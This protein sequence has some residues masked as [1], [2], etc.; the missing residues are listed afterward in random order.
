MSREKREYGF[1]NTGGRK[2]RALLL[3]LIVLAV[4]I[5][6]CGRTGSGSISADN[7]N[8]ALVQEDVVIQ[9]GDK[10]VTVEEV[11]FYVARRSRIILT[12][13]SALSSL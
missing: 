7:G 11:M 2:Q 9:V 4:S 3:L 8:E 6:A 13:W 10:K 5:T 12:M 1:R